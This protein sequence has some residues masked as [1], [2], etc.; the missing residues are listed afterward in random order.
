MLTDAA[1]PAP[2]R[3][4]CLY[5][6]S[7]TPFVDDVVR[8]IAQQI[9]AAG[10]VPAI[11]SIEQAWLR[12]SELPEFASLYVLP[13]DNPVAL[14]APPDPDETMAA[15]FG[16][17]PLVVPWAVQELCWDKIATQ[18]RLLAHGV[19]TPTAL[20]ASS[21]R[22]VREF[23]RE[24]RFAI[25][26]EPRSCGGAGHF[27][28]W[29]EGKQL[30]GDCGSHAYRIEPKDGGAIELDGDVLRHPGPY[31]V[32]RLVARQTRQGAEP[33]PVLRAYVESNEV[34]FWTERYREEYTRPA[35][36][37]IN[38]GRGA[39]YRFLHGASHQAERAALRAA[40]AL[41]IR[42]GVVDIVRAP[43][44]SPFVIEADVDGRHMM[45]DRTYKQLPEFRAHFDFDRYVARSLVQRLRTPPPD[46]EPTSPPEPRV[47]W[48]KA[49]ARAVPVRQG[50]LPRR[51]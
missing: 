6:E 35:D 48:A 31:Y 17:T 3:I 30:V 37:I 4:A 25:L 33:G 8:E 50:R 49:P 28:L 7:L 13:F 24:H 39:R 46:A 9:D 21:L 12:R 2:P 20:I 14:G 47:Y 44:G 26:K 27:V 5:G 15:L 51:Q 10:G 41:G 34:R 22:E 40:E 1:A 29:L 32:Q 43:D 42:A 19:P 11:V 23:V 38:A 18:E 16:E 36:W 45:I